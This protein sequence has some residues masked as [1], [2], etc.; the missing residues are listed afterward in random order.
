MAMQAKKAVKYQLKAKIALMGPS[1]SGKTYSALRLAGGMGPRKLLGN[2]EADRGYLYADQFNFDII[3]LTAPYT[4]EKYIELIEYAEREGYDTLIIDS[5]THEWSGRGGLLEVHSSMPGNSYTNWAKITPRHNAFV[6]KILYSK[7][8]I[9]TCLRGKD[10]YVMT[11]NE[12]G[13]QTPKKE[14]LGAD[15]R[16]NFEYEMMATLMLDQQTHVAMAMK[17]NTGLFEKRFEL[18]TEDHGKLLM[19]WANNG[20]AALQPDWNQ[21]A[22]LQYQQPQF[23]PQPNQFQQQPDLPFAA[24]PAAPTAPTAPVTTAEPVYGFPAYE[25]EIVGIWT[26]AGWDP[27]NQLIG[28]VQAKFQRQPAQLTV[29]ECYSIWQEFVAYVNEKMGGQ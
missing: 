3:D 5:G 19:Q 28:W 17:D 24:A 1:G 4:P 27:A 6:D 13:K 15:M 9:I 2:T 14:G 18:L 26:Q 21:M 22:Q 16:A 20:A 25:T 12:K 11:E 8:N 23:Q 29:E 10:V 7:I